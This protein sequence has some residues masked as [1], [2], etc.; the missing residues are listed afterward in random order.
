MKK[1]AYESDESEE[2]SDNQTESEFGVES[3]MTEDYLEIRI[4]KQRQYK[5]AM[6]VI[7]TISLI[8]S[9]LLIKEYLFNL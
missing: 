1:K 5:S 4:S 9:L 3:M 6:L 2:E 8:L 7:I